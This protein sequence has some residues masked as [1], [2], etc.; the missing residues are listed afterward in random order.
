MSGG[1]KRSDSPVEDGVLV[2]RISTS[3]TSSAQIQVRDMLHHT[4]QTIT[5]PVLVDSGAD[6]NLI[7]K[8]FVRRHSLPLRELEVPKK[9]LVLDGRLIEAVTHKTELLT[10]TLSSN[11]HE[12]L[13]LYVIISPLSPIFLGLPWLKRHNPHIDWSSP[14]FLNWSNYCHENCLRSAIPEMKL[15][16][17]GPPE[18]IDLTNIPKEYYDLQEVFSKDRALSF[19]PHRPYDCAIDLLPGSPLPT[20]R[21]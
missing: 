7:D 6:D 8:G 3:T 9:V 10:L 18:K 2:S 15:S 21:L 12:F 11:P 4:Q 19:P 20:K 17:P 5:V 1:A 14:T 16:C 13:E